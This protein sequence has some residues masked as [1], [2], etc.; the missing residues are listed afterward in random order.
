MRYGDK[1]LGQGIGHQVLKTHEML[2]EQAGW[3]RESLCIKQ[4]KS[5]YVILE[6]FTSINVDHFEPF[7]QTNN[8]AQAL[9]P[10]MNGKRTMHQVCITVIINLL[11]IPV[12]DP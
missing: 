9:F 11:L 2:S 7:A 4:I 3:A 5:T 1:G 10:C 8:A 12:L 6:V